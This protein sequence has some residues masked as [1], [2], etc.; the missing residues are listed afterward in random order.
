MFVWWGPNFTILYNDAYI[1]FLGRNK[2]PAVLGRPGREAWYDVWD[3]IGPM[4][5]SVRKTGKAT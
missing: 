1:A 2:H 3:T 5:E 4:L